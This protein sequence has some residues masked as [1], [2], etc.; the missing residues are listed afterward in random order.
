[1]SAI[2]TFLEGKK[3]YIVAAGMLAYQVLGYF[4]NGTPIDIPS[5]L[6][7]LGLAALR[8]GVAK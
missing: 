5:I 1:M 6:S 7:A 4:L 2:K 8:A 3:T